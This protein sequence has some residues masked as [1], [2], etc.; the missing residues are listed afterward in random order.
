MYLG[1]AMFVLGVGVAMGSAWTLAM[2]VPAA[3]VLH[4]GVVLR[5]ERYLE[6]RFGEDY[7]RLQGARPALRLAGLTSRRLEGKGHFKV[8][9]PR[10]WS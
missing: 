10:A 8:T 2:L 6:E 3:L 4:C 1:L 5:E 7:R 9:A